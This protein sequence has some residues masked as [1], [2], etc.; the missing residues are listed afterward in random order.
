MKRIAQSAD[1]RGGFML[2]DLM[3]A[4][5]IAGALLMSLTA[6]VGKLHRSER[7]MAESRAA[8]RRLEQALIALQTGPATAASRPPVEANAAPGTLDPDVH[9]ERLPGTLA[10]RVW[11]RLSVPVGAPGIAQPRVSLV[12]LIPAANAPGGAP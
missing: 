1:F 6:A 11:V 2:M 9:V 3:V 12:G 4:L 10:G 8:A 5:L 7:Q